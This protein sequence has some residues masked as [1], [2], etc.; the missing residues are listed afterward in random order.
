MSTLIRALV[1][2]GAAAVLLVAA[3]CGGGGKSPSVA[4]LGT[5]TTSSAQS[6]AP[7]GGSAQSQDAGGGNL[8]M[9][10]QNGE[11]FS[12][13]MRS[14]GV[15]NFPDPSS[16][17]ALS[18]GPGS[19]IDP[20]SP[21]FQKAQQTCQKLLPNGGRPSAQQIAKVQKGALAFSACM[22]KHGLKDF[23]D[24]TFSGGGVEMRLR[25]G[26]GSD[27]NPNSPLFQAAQ[28]A[29]QGNLPGK[30]GGGT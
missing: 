9:K 29:C 3:G 30:F 19:G 28:E 8:T 20:R 25:G 17:G 7:P 6:A 12:Q 21:K 18:I 1:I 4:S 5:T 22:R 27:L 23:P 16:N 14:N 10:V 26:P 24:P 11:K 13:C 2:A 15:A